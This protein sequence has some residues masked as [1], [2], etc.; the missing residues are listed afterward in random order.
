VITST[1]PVRRIRSQAARGKALNTTEWGAPI[2]AHARIATTLDR[3][4]HVDDDPVALDHAARLEGVGQPVAVE[5]LLVA[6]P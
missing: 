1:A 6:D 2:R 5:Q 3:H 4:R